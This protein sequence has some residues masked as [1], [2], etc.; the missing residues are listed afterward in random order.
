MNRGSGERQ[1]TWGDGG[2]TDSTRIKTWVVR[3]LMVLCGLMMLAFL[4]LAAFPWGMLKGTIEQRLTDRIGR[5]VTIGAMVREDAL[6][7]HPTV[8]LTDMRVPQPDWVKPKLGDLAQIGEA[9]VRFSALALLTGGPVVKALDL[10]GARLHFYRSA[11]GRENWTGEKSQASDEGG[12][13]PSLD[14]LE[15]SDSEIVYRDDKQRRSIEAALRVDSNGLRL[16]GS[17]DVRGHPVR[18]TANGAPILNHGAGA[19]WPFRVAIEGNAVGFTLDGTMDRP[20][21]VGHLRGAATA[22]AIDLAL[23]D[24][25]IEAGLPGTQPVRLTAQVL[26]D[27]PD[28][29]VTALKGAIGRSDLTGHATI[30]KRDGR[31]RI[32]GSIQSA[33]FDFDDLSSNEG[34]R[35]AA[36]KRARVGERI[37]P[38]TAIDL[39]A[40]ARTDGRLELKADRLLWPGSSP[41]RSLSGTLNLDHSRLVLEPLTLGLTRGILSGRLVVDQRKGG[42]RLAIDLTLRSARLLDFFPD[43]KIDGSLMGRIALVGRG[44]TVREAVGVSTGTIALVAR[45]GAIPARTAALLGQD[46]GKGL[47]VDKDKQAVLRCMIARLDVA[48]GVAQPNPVLIDTSRAQTRATGTV[49]LSSERMALSLTGAPKSRALLRLEGPVP[50]GGTIKAPD[51]RVPAETRSAKGIIKMIGKAIGGT[52][53]P[54]A[55]DADCDGLARAA[56]R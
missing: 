55:A 45:D 27:K 41:F 28:W 56:L 34:K 8:R 14:R 22:H 17:G 2:M 33:R 29:T 4:A 47:T 16:S 5:T 53:A 43:T 21:D 20:L 46:I 48:D 44:G 52:Q 39:K 40:V 54:R 26:R 32:D 7:F 11:E 18:V 10:R 42:P 24:A 31:T 23:L 49:A 38:D 1:V 19:R 50:I 3:G 37:V 36:A 9:R 35:K 13:R 12:V 30:R 25:I 15:V 6:S 51:I